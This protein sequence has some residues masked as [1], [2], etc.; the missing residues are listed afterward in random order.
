MVNDELE[1]TRQQRDRTLRSR[2]RDLYLE[3]EGAWF[4]FRLGYRLSLLPVDFLTPLWQMR[5]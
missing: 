4:E 1:I 3:L 5:E 2:A